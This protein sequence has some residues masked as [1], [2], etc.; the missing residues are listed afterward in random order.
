MKRFGAS[1]MNTDTVGNDH[2]FTTRLHL[3]VIMVKATLNGYPIGSYRKKAVIEN[4]KAL[5]RLLSDSDISLAL[6]NF[7]TSSHIFKQRIELLCVMATAIVSETYPLGSH[8]QK[9][10]QENL[11]TIVNIAFPKA[12]MEL[13]E[14]LLNVA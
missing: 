4:A 10:V 8:R 7:N 9:A 11:D 13:Y 12:K 6:L 3:L 14:D 5:H 1:N 2:I